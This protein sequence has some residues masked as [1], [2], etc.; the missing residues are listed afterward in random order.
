MINLIWVDEMLWRTFGG[1]TEVDVKWRSIMMNKQDV[2]AT[3]EIN[4]NLNLII[5]K[6]TA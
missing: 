2:D 6:I 1:I 3:V 5:S 4:L